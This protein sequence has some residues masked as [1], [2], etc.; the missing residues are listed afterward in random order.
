MLA[1]LRFEVVRRL[2]LVSTW[3]FVALFFGIGFLLVGAAG[4]AI[5]GVAVDFGAGSKLPVNA[6]LSLAFMFAL[7][8][9]M[10]VMVGASV[11]GRVIV[12]DVEHRM[13]PLVYSAPI[14]ERRFIAGRFLGAIAVMLLYLPFIAVGAF[15]ATHLPGIDPAR[16]GPNTF[17]AYFAPYLTLLLPNLFITTSLFFAV[18]L[19]TRRMLPVLVAGCVLLLGYLLASALIGDVERRTLGALLDP[20][21]LRALEAATT[22]WTVAERSQRMPSLSGLLLFNRLI[23]VGA[24]AALLAVAGRRFSFSR[25][26]GERSSPE[27]PRA[28]ESVVEQPG[29]AVISPARRFDLRAN[30]GLVLDLARVHIRET[31]RGGPFI[32]LCVAAALFIVVEGTSFDAVYGTPTYPVT[33]AMLEIVGGSFAIFL[34]IFIAVYAGELVHRE[35]TVGLAPISDALPTPTWVTFVAKLLALLALVAFMELGVVVGGVGLQLIHGYTHFELGLYFKSL[36]LV[37]FPRYAAFVALALAVHAVVDNKPLGHLLVTAAFVSSLLLP[38]LGFEHHLYLYGATP[39]SVY[40]DMNGYGPFVAPLVVF[41]VYWAC[42]SLVVLLVGYVAWVRGGERNVGARLRSAR[43]AFGRPLRGALAFALVLTFA[44]GAYAYHNTN[45]LNHYETE[46]DGERSGAKYERKY[47]ALAKEPRLRVTALKLDLDLYPAERRAVARGAAT[48]ENSG[49]E[50]SNRVLVSFPERA[51]VDA[52][53]LGGARVVEEEPELRTRIY[54]L[55]APLAPGATTT[56]RYTITYSRPGFVNGTD[57]GRLVDNG[58]FFVSTMLP[59]IGYEKDAELGDVAARKR[60]NLPPR[61]RM[62]DLDD[63]SGRERNYVVGDGD[64]VSLDVTV[65]TSSDQIAVGPGRLVDSREA[66]GRRVYHFV[67]TPPVPLFF[68]V[69]SA[70]YS[71]MKDRFG[72]IDLEIDYQAGHEYDLTRM[73]E[74]MKA[75]LAYT[76]ERFSPYQHDSVRIVEFPRYANYA[77]SLPGMIPYS[78]SVGFLARVDSGPDAIDLP[79]Y[80]TAHEVAHQW[81][82]HQ[83]LGADVQGATVLSETLA[84]YTALMVMKRKVGAGGMRRFLRY[85]LDR[86]LR[87]RGLEKDKEV[88]LLRVENQPYIHYSKGSLVMYR[89]QDM[90]GED[91]LDRVLSEF[92]VAERFKGPPYPTSRDLYDRIVAAAPAEDRAALADLFERIT[93]Y[94]LRATSATMHEV[95]PGVFDVEIG[96]A[97]KKFSADENGKEEERPIDDDIQFGVADDKHVPLATERRHVDAAEGKVTLRVHGAPVE[98]GIDPTNLFIDRKPEDNVMRIEKP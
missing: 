46:L 3:N 84:Q 29:A 79:L 10:G 97:A 36:Y 4:G 23:W 96:Y 57:D 17:S 22:Y 62:R 30:A 45:R 88:P 37:M 27:A 38:T 39:H 34:I 13:A 93:L 86:Y 42:V 74:G 72:D 61:P 49:K 71:T 55:P 26:A 44:V 31:A 89:T 54:A 35:R 75:A 78:E 91:V 28:A 90:L 7:A 9:H 68:G 60:Q 92:V 76:T 48:V 69:L 43:G 98:A 2:R 52:F 53:D 18:A 15:A 83:V 11:T 25:P 67:T 8:G 1:L 81:W 47:A 16:L 32:V 63:P 20:F 77:Q 70:R 73:M 56:L 40:S 85:E 14:G 95:E 41:K 58:T 80:V 66:G 87:A 21:G 64:W 51:S 59:Y 6:P 33:Y 94:D 50:A 19:F 12:D 65:S 82:A 24:A 5:A